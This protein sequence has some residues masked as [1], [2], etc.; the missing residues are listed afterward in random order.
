MLAFFVNRGCTFPTFSRKSCVRASPSD[1]NALTLSLTMNFLVPS[2]IPCV[3]ATAR[4][5]F[6][7]SSSSSC[8]VRQ[9]AVDH[10]HTRSQAHGAGYIASEMPH[11]SGRHH[12]SRTE[13]DFLLFS[14]SAVDIF[15]KTTCSLRSTSCRSP[16]HV[17]TTCS[18]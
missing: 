5:L 11:R 13:S 16:L 18:G 8:F 17:Q 14:S 1:I 15:R 2:I 6:S 4:L 12:T 3:V 10:F 9:V 7:S